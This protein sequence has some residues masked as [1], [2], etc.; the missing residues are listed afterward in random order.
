[1]KQIELSEGIVTLVD[2]EDFDIVSRHKWR[3]IRMS[4]N[5]CYAVRFVERKAFLL[6]RELLGLAH[7]DVRVVDHIDGNGLNNC[8]ANLR[9]CNQ[10]ENARNR[11]IH[12]NNKAGLKGVYRDNKSGRF[13]AQIR[14]NNTKVHLGSYGTP[15]EAHSVYLAAAQRLHGKFARAG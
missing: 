12:K 1:M 13:R 14:H 15:E 11:R 3:L 7:G 4:G 9:V 5:Y 2:D 10:A 6:H 8:R